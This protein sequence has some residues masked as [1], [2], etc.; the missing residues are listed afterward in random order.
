[1]S[2]SSI[3]ILSP[4]VGH[5]NCRY[6]INDVKLQPRK[7]KYLKAYSKYAYSK[8]R[9]DVWR[10]DVKVQQ[11]RFE[12][13]CFSLL[14]Q[15]LPTRFDWI[16]ECNTFECLWGGESVLIPIH[17]SET[18]KT[19]KRHRA[20]GEGL[21]KQW[22]AAKRRTW[23]FPRC[24]NVSG[25]VLHTSAFRRGQTA[26]SSKH[27]KPHQRRTMYEWMNETDFLVCSCVQPPN[28]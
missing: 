24:L 11:G 2:L 12:H 9:E 15:L 21:G 7:P 23:L 14:T 16:T 18:M 1:M 26:L 13:L 22:D 20:H 28:F 27:N 10:P 19:C 4:S 3:I 17:H 5:Q 6:Q 25:Q 8:G